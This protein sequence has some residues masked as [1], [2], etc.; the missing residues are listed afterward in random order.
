MTSAAPDHDAA[1][2]PCQSLLVAR[3][4][5]PGERAAQDD[6][7]RPGMWADE[8]R[9]DLRPLT[10]DETDALVR[11]ELRRRCPR[12]ER[13]T[14]VDM[15]GG[16][17]ALSAALRNA[18]GGAPHA[19]LQRGGIDSDPVVRMLAYRAWGD[20]D[21]RWYELRGVYEGDRV[22]S[23][24]R[25]SPQGRVRVALAWDGEPTCGIACHDAAPG[26]S[27]RVLQPKLGGGER[28]WACRAG[29]RP[30]EDQRRRSADGQATYDGLRHHDYPRR[31]GAFEDEAQDICEKLDFHRW[32]V[33]CDAT[34]GQVVI[35]AWRDGQRVELI[36]AEQVMVEAPY[37]SILEAGR[38]L[39]RQIATEPL[40]EFRGRCRD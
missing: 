28:E 10:Q 40:A 8:P 39:S 22:T 26:E 25:P 15:L 19:G 16:Q 29:D 11:S 24:E 31:L 38:L 18:S 36:I 9:T 20:R 4:L 13:A 12:D 5:T 35:A 7:P 6:E 33:R 3:D 32:E 17:D 34:R 23:L 37:D 30:R 14:L 27:V 21:R 2:E 1:I